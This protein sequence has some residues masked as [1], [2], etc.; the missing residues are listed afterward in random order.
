MNPGREAWVRQEL[1][2]RGF[3]QDPIRFGWRRGQEFVSERKIRLHENLAFSWLQ[4]TVN[5]CTFVCQCP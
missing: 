1:K 4:N 3:Y 5:P 2:K